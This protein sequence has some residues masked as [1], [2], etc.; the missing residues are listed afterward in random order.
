M[1][2]NKQFYEDSS[3]WIGVGAYYLIVWIVTFYPAF[4]CGLYISQQTDPSWGEDGA[5]TSGIIFMLIIYVFLQVLIALQKYEV[6]LFCYLLTLWPFIH[7]VYMYW[8][9]LD[10]GIG[11]T[12]E[13][14]PL[15]AVDWWPFW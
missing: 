8:H 5:M 7:Q 12:D 6:V 2:E 4:I 9:H 13:C 11:G 14:F 15:P 1:S 3:F 10:S